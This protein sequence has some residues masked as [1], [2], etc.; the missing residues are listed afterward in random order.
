ML[1]ELHLRGPIELFVALRSIPKAQGH[2]DI[3]IINSIQTRFLF[4]LK[5][6]VG[7]W[8]WK[9]SWYW[10]IG[11]S[12]S[13]NLQPATGVQEWWRKDQETLH[14][15]WFHEDRVNIIT[16]SIAAIIACWNTANNI[17]S[18]WNTVIAVKFQD[19]CYEIT[20]GTKNLTTLHTII[21]SFSS[22]IAVDKSWW[23]S[24]IRN[25]VKGKVDGHIYNYT[26][27]CHLK[28]CRCDGCRWIIPAERSGSWCY[29]I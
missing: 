2:I 18:N 15:R 12:T 10:C 8:Q 28:R 23:L 11:R 27:P 20:I 26:C 24:V 16:N 13:K 29:Q 14:C 17:L 6:T 9:H 1:P 22:L 7:W 25:A 3:I 19:S 21:I 5:G 4:K